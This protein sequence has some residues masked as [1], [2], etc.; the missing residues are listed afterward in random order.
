M[1]VDEEESEF[2]DVDEYFDEDDDN[3][4]KMLNY[5]MMLSLWSMETFQILI[6]SLHVYIF[7]FLVVIC[8]LVSN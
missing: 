3:E 1:Y 5:V 7:D 2:E 6:F 8:Y 4:R